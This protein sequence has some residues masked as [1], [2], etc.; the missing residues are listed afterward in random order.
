[1]PT[2][3]AA[4]PAA[5]TVSEPTV[6]GP[7]TGGKGTITVVGPREDLLATNGYVANE[8]FFGGTAT[9]YRPAKPLGP[10]GRWKFDASATA[11]YTSRMIVYRPKDPKDFNGTVYVEWLNLTA[12][13]ETSAVYS[14]VHNE[15]L[16]EGAAWIGVSAQAG[17]VQGTDSLVAVAGAPPGG[18]KATD[19]AR[20]DALTHPGDLYSFDI[21]S[22]AGVAAAGDAKGV[23]PLGNLSPKHLIAIGKSQS[24]FRLVTYVNGVQPTAGVYDGFLIASRHRSGAPL[25][26]TDFG[27]PDDTVPETAMIRTDSDV[28]VMVVQTETDLEQFQ[29]TRARQPDTKRFRLWEIAGSAHADTYAGAI[30]LADTGNG[31]AERTILDP[32]AANGGPLGCA[33]AINS[34]PTFAVLSASLSH[35]DAWVRG[36]TA[37]PKAPRIKTARIK[38]A[39]IKTGGS[40][41]APRIVRDARGNAVGGVRT[42]LVDVP[43]AA[44]TGDTNH[45]GI[46]CSLFGTTTPFDAA[47]IAALYPN[48]ADYVREFDASADAAVKRGFWLKPESDNFKAAARQLNISG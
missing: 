41:D 28:P 6:Q 4:A 48:P 13:F 37:P 20:Y 24:A 5:S 10:D 46:F 7:V 19:P 30:G 18:L 2:V 9:A 26:P 44:L 34:G 16:R 25:G 40:A 31:A 17:G 42:P 29:S 8:Y 36:G 39:R 21:F 15:V 43:L 33:V 14:L 23:K 45:G 12:G 3:G 1:M 11:P 47:T 32:S 38:S 27:L 22:Q 35:L